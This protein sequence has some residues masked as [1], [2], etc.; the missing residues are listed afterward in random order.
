M[1]WPN[2]GGCRDTPS[3][4]AGRARGQRRKANAANTWQGLARDDS[5]QD[6]QVGGR[7]Y[8]EVARPQVQF[9]L[10]S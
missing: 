9:W 10:G 7:A 8:Y 3:G 5:W 2:P 6:G 1:S 4:S